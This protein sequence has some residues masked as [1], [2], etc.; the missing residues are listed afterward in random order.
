ME[1]TTDKGIK[2]NKNWSTPRHTIESTRSFS[3]STTRQYLT[4]PSDIS[5]ENN[6]FPE[7][8]FNK[9]TGKFYIAD[10][11]TDPKDFHLNTSFK[12]TGKSIFCNYLRVWVEIFLK[13]GDVS[14]SSVQI[15]DEDLSQKLALP[16]G[17]VTENI[18][19][20]RMFFIQPTQYYKIFL[21]TDAGTC[22]IEY[23]SINLVR[24][25]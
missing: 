11:E 6:L 8:V 20:H 12:V 2:A 18:S 17:N 7:D 21:E 5:F 16:I 25:N 19:E 9:T 10:T 15:N 23:S 22:D 14:L 1:I 13:S 24:N 3:V 4:F